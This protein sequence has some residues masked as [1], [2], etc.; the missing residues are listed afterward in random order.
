M[1]SS[2]ERRGD[3]CNNLQLPYLPAL[4]QTEIED[5]M[6]NHRKTPPSYEEHMQ[7]SRSLS[8]GSNGVEQ[9]DQS[10]ILTDIMECIGSDKQIIPSGGKL[11]LH[12]YK[13]ASSIL[14]LVYIV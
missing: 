10:S 6:A 7:R 5:T 9:D 13:F 11:F 8:G 3:S 1:I 4:L 2:I 14:P 12:N